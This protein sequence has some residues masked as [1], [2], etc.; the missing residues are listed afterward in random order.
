MLTPPTLPPPIRAFNALGRG[1]WQLGLRGRLDPEQLIRAAQKNTGLGDFGAGP[2]RKDL[3]VLVDALERE[4]HLTSFGRFIVRR[5]LV[6]G[7]EIQLQVQD[8]FRRHPEIAQQKIERPIVIIGMPRTGTTILHELFALDP[9][10]RVPESW[11]VARPCPPPDAATFERDPRIKR[12]EKHLDGFEKVIPDVRRIHRMGARL[13]QE[14]VAITGY[15]FNGMMWPVLFRIPSYARWLQEE[16]DF[17]PAYRFHRRFLQLLQWRNPRTRWVLKSPGHLWRLQALMTEYPDACLVQTHRDPL[18]IESSNTSLTTVFR[19][20]ASD[21]VDPHEIAQEW[22][23]Y[24]MHA[25][26]DSHRVRASGAIPPAQALD[27]QFR[28]FMKEPAI[29]MRNIYGRFELD[30]PAGMDARIAQYIKDNPA[31]KHGVH[32]Y[33]WEDTGLDYAAEREKARPYQEYFQVQS[34]F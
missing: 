11:E 27:V 25:L 32:A 23:G 21:H 22:S 28:A 26:N 10:V 19:K 18:K 15:A 5:Q 13:P 33:H 2:Y 8:W 9:Q 1:L 30:C 3:D 29:V 24:L 16:A 20:M 4:A 6:E 17:G 12:M 34:E 14:C 7:L 31:D